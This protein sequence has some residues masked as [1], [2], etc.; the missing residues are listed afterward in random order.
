MKSANYTSKPGSFLHKDN[1]DDKT[2]KISN[3]AVSLRPSTRKVHTF[4]MNNLIK[5]K[6]DVPVTG[7]SWDNVC[8]G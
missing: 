6:I 3:R 4:L 1:I 7:G 5:D 2:L 8:R